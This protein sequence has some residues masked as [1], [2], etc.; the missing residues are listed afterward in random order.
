[1]KRL[2]GWTGLLFLWLFAAGG[3]AIAGDAACFNGCMARAGA[4]GLGGA[5]P[6]GDCLRACGFHVS[7]D[8][9]CLNSCAAQKPGQSTACVAQCTYYSEDELSGTRLRLTPPH[10]VFTAPKESQDIMLNSPQ[11][12]TG[13]GS[14]TPASQLAPTVQPLSP[15][16]NY[17]VLASCLQQGHMFS[18]CLS[19]SRY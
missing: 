15:S 11:E 12:T 6:M 4:S 8:Y 7:I 5:S 16:T 13:D 9:R 1:M 10:D 3:A 17:K 19:A 14:G 2:A 18:Y